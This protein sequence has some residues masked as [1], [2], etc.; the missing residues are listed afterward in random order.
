MDLSTESQVKYP[1]TPISQKDTYNTKIT[2]LSC[3]PKALELDS[4]VLKAEI[5]GIISTYIYVSPKI[6]I[7]CQKM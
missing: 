7:V 5:S 1:G 3:L 4:I 6:K 2:E